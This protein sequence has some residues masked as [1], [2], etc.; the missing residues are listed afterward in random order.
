LTR[1]LQYF[2]TLRPES[3]LYRVQAAIYVDSLAVAVGLKGTER[4]LDFGCG[5]GFVAALL[6]PRVGEL[7]WWD[8]SPN[9]RAATA[10]HTAHLPHANACDLTALADSP[11]QDAVWAGPAFDV[12]LVNSVVQ[13]MSPE[14]IRG[15]L[16]RWRAMLSAD[17]RLV[18]SDLIP[19]RHN[20]LADIADL[21]RLGV[22]HGSPLRAASDALGGVARYMRANRAV[23]LTRID[24][25]DLRGWAAGAGFE[26]ALLQDNLTHFR[27]RWGG[28]LRRE[29]SSALRRLQAL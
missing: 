26:L 8:G 3:P 28:V 10:R 6:A 5:F 7:W 23:P 21:L 11:P 4:V 22:R 17:G 24:V 25:E 20:G 18:L 2:D 29:V 9:M 16:G 13:Y 12:I 14:D 27:T 15:W 1:W 19:A